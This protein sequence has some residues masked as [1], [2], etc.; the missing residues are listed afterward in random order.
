M[1]DF[2]VIIPTYKD[3]D[4][5]S[6]CIE[7]LVN[8]KNERVEFEVIIV[9]N[10]TNHDPPHDL[11]KYS[12][13]QLKILHEPRPGSY[14]ARNSGAKLANGKY[15]AFTD[16]DCLPDAQWL[17]NAWQTFRSENCDL[18]GG[19]IDLFK[20]E[21]GG[22]W[23]FLYE[24]Y[25]SFR[26]DTHVPKG[27]SVTAN[28]FVKK[29]VFETLNG[30]DA[31]VNSGGDWEFTERAVS[32]GFN[33]VYGADVIVKHPARKFI[34]QILKKQ[35]R[36]AAWGYLNV[37]NKYGHS[38]LRIIGSNLLRGTPSAFKSI[39]YPDRMRDKLIV[40]FISLQI[41]IYKVVLQVLFLMKIMSPE[42]IRE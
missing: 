30:F 4:R 3:W 34:R 39:K 16:A 41:H 26:Q 38:G 25:T 9:D 22:D 32:E 8:Q 18:I 37:K 31:T 42:K 21:G 11:N 13:R 1:T 2:S 27:R 20:P 17:Q 19:R 6:L 24:S 5:L 40:L 28:L 10:A 7:C 35:K 12:D 36:F 33:M 23:A 15:L 29:T 14:A